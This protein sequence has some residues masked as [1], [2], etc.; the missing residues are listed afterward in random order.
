MDNE[1]RAEILVKIVPKMY[2]EFFNKVSERRT[3]SVNISNG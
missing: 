3:C 2:I 1:K